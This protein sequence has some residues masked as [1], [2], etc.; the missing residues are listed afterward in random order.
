VRAGAR[1][2]RGNAQRNSAEATRLCPA[3]YAAVASRRFIGAKPW[4]RP[5]LPV[6][7]HGASWRRR[8]KDYTP[9]PASTLT[10]D[11]QREIPY[12]R[13]SKNRVLVN[14]TN[15][16]MPQKSYAQRIHLLA[17]PAGS[18]R[19]LTYAHCFYLKREHLYLGSRFRMS[20]AVLEIKK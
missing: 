2:I 9:H 20:D 11:T 3:G 13:P 14:S 7:E 12:A 1:G 15:P 6:Q 19:N 8:V 10:L 4:R 16:I 18:M 17:K 5:I